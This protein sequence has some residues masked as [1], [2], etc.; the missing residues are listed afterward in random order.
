MDTVNPLSSPF[1]EGLV[2]TEGLFE[3]RGGGAYLI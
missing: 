1:E 3:K 2:E